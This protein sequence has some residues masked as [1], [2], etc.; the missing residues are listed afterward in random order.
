MVQNNISVDI[1]YTPVVQHSF[2]LFVCFL[3]YMLSFDEADEE[4]LLSK[5]KYLKFYDVSVTTVTVSST[6][7]WLFVQVKHCLYY[8]FFLT[9]FTR[10]C[11]L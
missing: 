7:W 4:K 6:L 3:E 1:L 5:E 8:F 9:C 11:G 10:V 2:S